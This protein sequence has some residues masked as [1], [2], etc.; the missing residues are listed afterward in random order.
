MKKFLLI[1]SLVALW[2]GGSNIWNGIRYSKPQVTTLAATQ[3]GSLPAYVT[4]QD[5]QFFVGD[6]MTPKSGGDFLYVPVRAK[7]ADSLKG[8]AQVATQTEVTGMPEPLGATSR[9]IASYRKAVPLMS[10]DVVVILEGEHPSIL[11]GFVLLA[12]S[13]GLFLLLGLLSGAGAKS[14]P[15]VAE[16]PKL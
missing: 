9:E 13:V 11:F 3:P 2:L 6:T 16:P 12:V 10:K 7:G 14:E 8:L 1:A 4:L 15:P 5:L